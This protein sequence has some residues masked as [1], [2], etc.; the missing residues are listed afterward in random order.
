MMIELD[1]V[2]LNVAVDGPEDAPVITFSNS[3]MTDIRLWEP[4][5]R[6]LARDFRIIRYDQRGHG[7]SSASGEAY[8][9]DDLAD[10][11][12]AIWDRLGIRQSHLVGLSMGGMTAL[13][14]ALRHPGRLS[15]CI[16]C[17][18]RADAPLAFRES[19]NER[20]DLANAEGMS[21]LAEPTVGRWFPADFADAGVRS[22]VRDMVGTTPLDGFLG[23]VAAI[24]SLD[25]LDRVPSL[26]VPALYLAGGSDGVLPQAMEDLAGLTP[27]SSYVRF[28]GAG[29]LIN[30]ERPH[31]FSDAVARFVSQHEPASSS[32]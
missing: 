2:T 25:Y 18:M 26:R 10:D 11:I 19:W 3:L 1:N 20:I 22:L 32:V 29:H 27:G 17:S 28:E 8:G 21:A 6:D 31:E 7:A 30:L 24:R 14:L 13:G 5:V 16:M 9:F 4:Q 12:V 23:G 15:S